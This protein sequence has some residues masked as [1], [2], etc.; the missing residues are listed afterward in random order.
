[1]KGQEQS[2]KYTK[3]TK[4]LLGKQEVGIFVIFIA[5]CVVIGVITPKF[6]KPQNIINILRQ[7]SNVGIM[8][9]GQAMVIIVA[10]IDLSVG[11]VL[12][13]SSCI[14]ATL[15][16]VMDPWAAMSIAL[17]A[18]ATIGMLNGF[19]SVKIGITPFIAT[20]GVQ[21]MTRGL[22]FLITNGIP[23]KFNFPESVGF[24][25]GGAFKVG[26]SLS[27][28]MSI[29]IM[30]V[31][32]T[33][34]IVLLSKTTFG[35]NLYAV[36]DNERSSK[37]SGI[38][39]DKVKIAAYVISGLLA[40]LAGILSV[41]NLTTAEASAGDGIELNVIAAVVIGGVSMSGGEGSVVGILIGAAIMG[42]IKNSFILLNFKATWQTITIGFLILLAVGIDCV[43]KKYK[44]NKITTIGKNS[45]TKA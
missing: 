31:V 35:R 5:L 16:R 32:Y 15:A 40:A 12:A 39:S 28:P 41:G 34:G 6:V 10:G 7:I 19:L 38:N 42:V 36:G 43:T 22:S 21:M 8:S 29:I 33:I 25:G 17:L 20:L 3:R 9:V 37:L 2:N 24:L 27:V 30:L 13:L 18:G 44:A 26:E 23:V 4:M 14:A 11:S 1:M 45:I